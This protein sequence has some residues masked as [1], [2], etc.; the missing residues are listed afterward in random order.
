[1]KIIRKKNQNCIFQLVKVI[2]WDNAIII[3][4]AMNKV[5][6]GFLEVLGIF[7]A[8]LYLVLRKVC[9]FDNMHKNLFYYLYTLKFFIRICFFILNR[10]FTFAILGNILFFKSVLSLVLKIF[11]IAFKKVLLY[12]ETH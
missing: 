8:L 10:D 9:N 6:S 1:M 12:Q 5:I 2:I 3:K 7:T 11:L 4:N